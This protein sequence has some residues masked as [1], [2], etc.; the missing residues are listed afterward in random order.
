MQKLIIIR[1][2]PAS[3]KST[4]AKSLRDFQKKIA[5]L[6]VDNFKDFFSEDGTLGLEYANEA[7]IV[8]LEF[9]VKKVLM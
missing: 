5:W 1:G 8:T 7:A 2:A 4:I 3:G 9:L 6:K